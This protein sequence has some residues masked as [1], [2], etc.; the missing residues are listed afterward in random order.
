MHKVRG[1]YRSCTC[2]NSENICSSSGESHPVL[3]QTQ[4]SGPVFSWLYGFLYYDICFDELASVG[5][6]ESISSGGA[7]YAILENIF[8]I[9]V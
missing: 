2:R 9:L 4:G 6:A 3:D 5:K 1:N 8:H 7:Q